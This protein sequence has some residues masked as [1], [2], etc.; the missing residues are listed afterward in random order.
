[1]VEE[2]IESGANRVIITGG[3]PLMHNLDTLTR[4]LRE[5]GI[6]TH[7]ETSGTHPLSGEWDWITFSPKKFKK[8]TEEIFQVADE[9]KVIVFHPSDIQWALELSARV[10]EGCQNLLQPV[11]ERQ[12]DV[13]PIIRQQ[14][15]Q[16]TLGINFKLRIFNTI[17]SAI[18]ATKKEEKINHFYIKVE[19]KKLKTK[20]INAKRIEKTKVILQKYSKVL[21]NILE[22]MKQKEC[23]NYSINKESKTVEIEILK[24]NILNI[25]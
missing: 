20:E 13:L 19:R 18:V 15:N 17:D 3:E 6:K 9:M 22:I 2:V 10:T 14:P 5:E 4:L 11:W 12:D 21:I 7:I 8:P 23:L 16:K 25:I 24:L 1:L